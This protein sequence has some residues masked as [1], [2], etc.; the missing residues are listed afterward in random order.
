FPN[1]INNVLAFPGIF[2]GALDVRATHINEEMKKAAVRA[3]ADLIQDDELSSE[4]V[5]PYPF[6][7]FVAPEVAIAV[8][9]AA[10]NSGVS[11]IKISAMTVYEKTLK[12]TETV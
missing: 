6:N 1:Q 4:Y 3:I 10:M 7:K 9:E 5:I 11:R 8:A 12:L 2:R